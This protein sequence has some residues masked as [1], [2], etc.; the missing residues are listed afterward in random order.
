MRLHR[1]ALIMGLIMALGNLLAA[2]PPLTNAPTLT[3][4]AGKL[5][6][7]LDEAGKIVD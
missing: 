1:A 7:S 4:E 6:F 3:L 2:T 5:R